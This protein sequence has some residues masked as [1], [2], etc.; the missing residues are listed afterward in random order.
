VALIARIVPRLLLGVVVLWGAATL[1]FLAI[2]VIPGDTA[3]LILG[4]P[5]ARPTP[6]A[7]AAVRAE[8][9]LDEPIVVQ[10]LHYLGSVARGDL[11]QS[12]R[13]RIPV[14][15]AIG[16]QLGS[17]AT[18]A[19]VAAALA[20]TLTVVVAVLSAQR[21]PWIRRIVSSIE[22][23]LSAAPSFVIGFGLLFVFAFTFRLLP[24]G[25]SNGIA[26]LVLPAVTLALVL[27]GPLSQVLRNELEEVLEQPFVLTARTRGLGDLAVRLGHALRHAAIPAVTITGFIVGGL[28]G[29]S[30][31]AE[32]LF[33]RS[34]VGSLML[35]SVYNKDLPVILGVVLLSAA[36]FVVVNLVIDLL[37]TAID[38]RM[39]TS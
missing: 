38:P 8:Y 30:V 39:V 33:S 20:V 16:Q 26:A 13:L 21:S 28:L 18:L 32:T 4:G 12:Y 35:Q 10:Y 31:I 7:L 14:T 19:G 27:F 6:E 29:G 24:S 11:G 15:E 25:G 1:T 23:F 22:V 36:V 9:L 37:Y 34:G 2:S 3:L 17:T 5:D